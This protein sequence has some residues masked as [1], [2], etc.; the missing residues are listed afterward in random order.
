MMTRYLSAMGV[1]TAEPQVGKILRATH[2]PY[3]KTHKNVRIFCALWYNVFYSQAITYSTHANPTTP[4]STLDFNPV[5][6]N[7]VVHATFPVKNNPTFYEQIC[8]QFGPVLLYPFF[9]SSKLTVIFESRDQG[10]TA[11]ENVAMFTQL[12]HCAYFSCTMPSL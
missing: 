2:C 3:H 1:V 8:S 4:K 6:Y 10:K 11:R 5:P 7:V 9:V 12:G